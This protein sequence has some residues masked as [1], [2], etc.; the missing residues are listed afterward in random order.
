MKV[1]YFEAQHDF[2]EILGVPESAPAPQIRAAH[3]RLVF[4]FHPDRAGGER[5]ANERRVMLINLAATVLLNP[6]ARARYDELRRAARTGRLRS[7]YRRTPPPASSGA[8]RCNVRSSG[9]RTRS[10]RGQRCSTTL[11]VRVGPLVADEFTRR[12]VWSALLVTLVIGWV[13]E[14]TRPPDIASRAQFA[15]HAPPA[16]VYA[17]DYPR[18][19]IRYASSDEPR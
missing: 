7:P 13:A 1:G 19:P 5:A 15:V 9:Y 11:G 4:H 10:P 8:G 16:I 18:Y 6:A 12:L 3:R 2:Y 14:R 17:P